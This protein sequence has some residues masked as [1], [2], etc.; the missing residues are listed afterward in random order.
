MSDSEPPI[1][2]SN[3]HNVDL[4]KPYIY[5]IAVRSGKREYRYVG[6]GSSSS[7]MDAYARN[8]SRILSGKPK[9]PAIKRNGEPQSEGNIKFRYVHL[10]LAIAATRGW[11]I[12]H[13]PLENCEKK[14]HT[15][16][17]K[18]RIQERN[19]NMNDGDSWFVED[20]ERLA[21]ELE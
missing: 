10:V 18:L 1:E 15:M 4:T 3:P 12:E 16:I 20:F 8:V 6:K 21:S 14:E 5:F 7:R 9:R 17:E 11:E 2:W 13:Y 19:C